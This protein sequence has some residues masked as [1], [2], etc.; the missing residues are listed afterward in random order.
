MLHRWR[1]LERLSDLPLWR[2]LC[3]ILCGAVWLFIGCKH[4]S[5]EA[6]IYSAAPHAP[7]TQTGQIYPVH[8]NHGNLRYVT[9]VEFEN[10][11]FWHDNAGTVIGI[12]A[13]GMGMLIFLPFRNDGKARTLSAG[14]GPV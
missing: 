9:I 8:V 2:K 12:C 4:L 3:L 13:L 11:E 5:K 10:W 7:I 14:S 1:K 6:G